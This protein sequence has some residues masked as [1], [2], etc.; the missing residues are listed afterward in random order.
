[1]ADLRGSG[2]LYLDVDL[3]YG[4]VAPMQTMLWLSAAP[5]QL[6]AIGQ[7]LAGHPEVPF[8]AATT[9]ASNIYATVL[10]SGPTAL[11]TYLATKI[12]AL[13]SVRGL[14]TAPVIRTLKQL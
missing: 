11:F 13:P 9:G 14:E 7:A 3:D 12:A 10:C 2:V 5:D 1:V 6:L 8:V 4:R